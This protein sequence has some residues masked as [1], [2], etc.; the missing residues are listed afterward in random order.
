MP[1]LFGIFCGL[2]VMAWLF[3]IFGPIVAA[4]NFFIGKF[5]MAAVLMCISLFC[6]SKVLHDFTVPVVAYK[7][8]LILGLALEIVKWVCV[9][10]WR[11]SRQ[12]L[13]KSQRKSQPGVESEEKLEPWFDMQEE[14]PQRKE[15]PM[16]DVTPRPR[17]LDH[18]R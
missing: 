5:F 16:K 17:R 11:G 7:E 15:R 8:L 3:T 6:A 13:G 18:A 4:L 9:W 10:L 2:F 12:K 14:W 1:V